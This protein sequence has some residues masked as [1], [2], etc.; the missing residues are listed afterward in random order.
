MVASRLA[1]MDL[2]VPG[3]PMSSDVVPAG[4]GDFQG[5]LHVFLALDFGEIQFVIGG[6]AS[7]ILAMSTFDGRDFD[8]A[9]EKLRGLA[10]ILD[11]N[12][13]Q[14]VDDRGFGGVFR[15]NEHA[16]FPVGLRAQA[17]PAK[18]LCTDARR[19]SARVRRRRRNCPSWSVSICSLA[20]SIPRAMG[21]SK[22]G[23]SF[24]TSAGAR[25]MVV[26]PMGN[27]KPELASAVVTRSRDSF[28]A[29]SGRPTMTMMV[30][31]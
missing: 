16:G 9:F 12:D 6:H 19:R 18:R 17:Q 2:P 21:R 7:K 10:E 22:L 28:T 13:L 8:F 24:F 29:A 27:L 3:G 1:S 26:R 5:A 31:P 30:S 4:G 23:P 11:G 20:A 15:R 25:L 14:A